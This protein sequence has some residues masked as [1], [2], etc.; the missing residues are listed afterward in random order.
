MDIT[1]LYWGLTSLLTM[2][3]SGE[4]GDKFTLRLRH[5][6]PEDDCFSGSLLI[7]ICTHGIGEALCNAPDK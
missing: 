6:L 4:P 3:T 5:R 1:S 2:T 7:D